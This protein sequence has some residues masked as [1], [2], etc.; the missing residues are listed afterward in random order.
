M[1]KLYSQKIKESRDGIRFLC[2]LAGGGGGEDRS[3]YHI[4]SAV[5]FK[6]KFYGGGRGGGVCILNRVEKLLN[7]FTQ[8]L[9]SI[10]GYGRKQQQLDVSICRDLQILLFRI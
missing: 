7:P 1:V 4:C 5:I 10:A 8:F 9:Q 6:K 2:V 3:Q